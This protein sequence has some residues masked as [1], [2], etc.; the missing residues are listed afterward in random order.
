LKRSSASRSRGNRRSS[1]AL[2][3]VLLALLVAA[4]AASG[5]I[6]Y[7]SAPREAPRA[8]QD[9]LP[10]SARV[11]RVIDGDTVELAGGERLRYIGVN[12]PES[13]RK[14]GGRWVEEPEPFGRDA[15]E[16][17][18]RLVD[19]RTVRL[20]YDVQPRDRYGRLLAYAYVADAS[21]GELMV[22][23]E[24]LR[25]GMAQQ[26]TI[27]PNVKHADRF[28]EIAAEARRGKRGLWSVK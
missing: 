24:L 7:Q 23:A 1:A 19:G 27:P 18:R 13:R 28:R 10:D 26:M 3:R 20:E 9:R 17:N 11:A 14:R 15:T 4:G 16:A 6:P 22:N 21:G 2:R 12:T 8:S 5:I 25:L